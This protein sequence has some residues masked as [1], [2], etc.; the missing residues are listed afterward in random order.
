M[1]E[2]IIFDVDGTL[3]DSVDAHARAWQ[4]ALAHFGFAL[5]FERVRE[6]IGKGADQLMPAL[7]PAADLARIYHALDTYRGELFK[8]KYL[9]TVRGFPRVRE[10]FERLLGDG[11]KVALASSAK[12]DELERY[13]QLAGIADLVDVETHSDDVE[14]SKPEPDIF[15]A[16]L[17]RLGYPPPNVCVVVGDTPYD[18]IAAR[19]AHVRTVGVLCGGFSPR[20]LWDAGC[21]AL[22]RDPAELL[23][24]YTLSPHTVFEP[25][26]HGDAAAP[27]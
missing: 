26:E 14:Q 9:P 19:R 8:Q 5:P 12:G 18:A 3:V 1:T 27:A 16:A 25:A 10:L 7:V 17:E 20:S 22:Y 11:L 24:R 13:K 4:E 21:I 6:Q 23:E 15:Q 2:A